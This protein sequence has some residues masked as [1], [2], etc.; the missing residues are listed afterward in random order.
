MEKK[1]SESKFD[2]VDNNMSGKG[3]VRDDSRLAEEQSMTSKERKRKG[4]IEDGMLP[5]ARKRRVT[6]GGLTTDSG[7]ERDLS[8]DMAATKD[9]EMKSYREEETQVL[10]YALGSYIDHS[11]DPDNDDRPFAPI[12]RKVKIFLMNFV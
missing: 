2:E 9:F 3:Y 10:P 5:I 6:A 1:N 7:Y 4:G 12:H 8:S 11:L